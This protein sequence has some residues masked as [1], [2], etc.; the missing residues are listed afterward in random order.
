MPLNRGSRG[1]SLPSRSPAQRTSRHCKRRKR[2]STRQSRSMAALPPVRPSALHG[3]HRSTALTLILLAIASRCVYQGPRAPAFVAQR[4]SPR[5]LSQ[6]TRNQVDEQ[7]LA[8]MDPRAE[9]Q[10]HPN[11]VRCLVSRRDSAERVGACANA[12]SMP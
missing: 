4:N 11:E 8:G 6:W 12:I 7:R 2:I 1:R 10:A 9:G 5:S 3:L